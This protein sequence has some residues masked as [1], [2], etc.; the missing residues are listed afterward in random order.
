MEFEKVKTQGKSLIGSIIEMYAKQI[1]GAYRK[2]DGTLNIGLGLKLSPADGEDV[3]VEAS[4]T[5]TENK[6]K[7]SIEFTV[8]EQ[9]DL[10]GME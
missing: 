1:E 6:V 10:P 8:C 7:D 4:I 5:F 3:K 2:N 9:P